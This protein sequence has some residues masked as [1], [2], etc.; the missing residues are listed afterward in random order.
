MV[1]P[2][3]ALLIIT[4]G[5]LVSF[6]TA[7]LLV[8]P[9]VSTQPPAPPGCYYQQVQCVQ[10]PCEPVLVCPDTPTPTPS[11]LDSSEPCRVAGCSSQLCVDSS[12]GDVVSTCEYRADYA[13][14]K[15]AICERQPS[16]A[17]GWTQTP[18]LV[19]CLQ[20]PPPLQ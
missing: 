13:C 1:S 3:F 5:L 20:N 9:S 17:C 19:S 6:F 10:A 16:G 14:Y 15:T 12:S 8:R 18:Q 7:L 11:K 4:A 2:K